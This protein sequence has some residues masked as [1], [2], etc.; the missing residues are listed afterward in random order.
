MRWY[1]KANEDEGM[2]RRLTPEEAEEIVNYIMNP[3]N[4]HPEMSVEQWADYVLEHMDMLSRPPK[5]EWLYHPV[6]IETIKGLVED[7]TDLHTAIRFVEEDNPGYMNH[8]YFEDSWLKYVAAVL[9]E[10][11]DT[12]YNDS[13]YS[14]IDQALKSLPD[15]VYDFPKVQGLLA[16]HAKNIKG[17]YEKLSDY[18]Q[19]KILDYYR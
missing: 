11:K 2:K 1:K 17:L 18:G 14:D 9:E 13:H 5:K 8:P 4:P 3:R 15:Y 19:N 12:M 10:T 7:Y 6:V 16:K